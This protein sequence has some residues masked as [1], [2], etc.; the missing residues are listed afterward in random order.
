MIRKMLIGGWVFDMEY[1]LNVDFGYWEGLG[2]FIKKSPIRKM[3]EYY[4]Q[5]RYFRIDF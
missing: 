1:G 3:M 4:F 5:G 2:V